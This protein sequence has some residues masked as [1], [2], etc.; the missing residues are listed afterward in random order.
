MEDNG[1]E[2]KGSAGLEGVLIRVC[3]CFCPACPVSISC[4][5]PSPSRASIAPS[6]LFQMEPWRPAVVACSVPVDGSAG[7]EI[8]WSCS[9]EQLDTKNEE[10]GP[11]MRVWRKLARGQAVFSELQV[12]D[13]TLSIHNALGAG[14][15]TRFSFTVS[16]GLSLSLSSSHLPSFSTCS[17]LFSPPYR[18]PQAVFLR[19]AA[20]DGFQPYSK[21]LALFS[22]VS[23]TRSIPPFDLYAA[24]ASCYK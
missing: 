8:A 9:P 24:H 21:P 23:Q 16:S 14:I 1:D 10:L 13:G 20:M 12:E 15:L 3:K 18:K 17:C 5:L 6:P 11:D 19:Q 4:H 22:Q 7:G 2:L